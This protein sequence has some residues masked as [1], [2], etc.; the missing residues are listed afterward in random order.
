MPDYDKRLFMVETSITRRASEPVPRGARRVEHD[1]PEWATDT[2]TLYVEAVD[3]GDARHQIETR[4][5]LRHYQVTVVGDLS[6]IEQSIA[7]AQN[8]AK[9]LRQQLVDVEKR[10]QHWWAK[11]RLLLK[12]QDRADRKAARS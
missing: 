6:M 4:Y 8:R 7:D 5:G 1:D 2:T 11:H 9:G 12:A 10:E 3:Q